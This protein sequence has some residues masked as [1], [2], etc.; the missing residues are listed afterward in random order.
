MLKDVTPVRLLRGPA[1]SFFDQVARAEEAG[2]DPDTL[3]SLLGRGRAKRGM[4]EGDLLEGELEIGQVSALLDDLP[5]AGEL[6]ERIVNEYR[7]FGT[8]HMAPGFHWE[9]LAHN[10]G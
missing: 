2:A 6:V 5:G 8:A 1:G 9:A 7:T 3:R 4:R 10:P